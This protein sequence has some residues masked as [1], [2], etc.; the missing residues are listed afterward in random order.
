MGERVVVTGTG[1]VTAL[2]ATAATT[3]RAVRDDQAPPRYPAGLPADAAARAATGTVALDASALGVSAR[4]AWLMGRPA[5]ALLAAAR[6]AVA[7]ANL[8]AGLVAPEDIA[9]FAAMGMVDPA[10]DDLR[11]AVMSSLGPDGLELE[12]FFH[13]GHRTIH[14]LWPL[15]MLNNVGFCQVCASLG[16][17]GDNAVFSPGVDAGV[18]AVVEAT[19]A[20]AEGR[21]AVALAGGAG[22]TVSALSLARSRLVGDPHPERRGCPLGEGGGVLVLEREADARER[23]ARP[24]AVVAGWGY[25]FGE[26]DSHARTRALRDAVERAGVEVEAI[27]LAIVSGQ[28][29]EGG[30]ALGPEPGAAPPLA[31]DS[32]SRLG[33]LLAGAAVVDAVLATQALSEDGRGGGPPRVALVSARGRSGHA[34]ALLLA[35]VE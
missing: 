35:A 14:P 12:R 13:E 28:P 11:G 7:Q 29:R 20:V 21:A 25:A 26:D 8:P 2:G 10:V 4:E 22:E 27:E 1:A 17:R 30:S 33:D 19:A 32:A 16:V 6:E 23:G 3:W 24:L 5:L 34:A 9:F 15:A 31:L 18:V